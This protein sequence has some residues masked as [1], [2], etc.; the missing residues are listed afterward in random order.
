MNEAITKSL[1]IAGG[2]TGLARL[3]GVSRQRVH[4]WRKRGAVPLKWAIEIQQVTDGKV[5]VEDFYPA[6][7]RH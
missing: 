4:Q 1:R 2:Q 3:L 5:R 6:I 7:S